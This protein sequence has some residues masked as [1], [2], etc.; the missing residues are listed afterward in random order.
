MSPL[1]LDAW[2][3]MAWLK[4]QRPASERVRLLLDA[5]DRRDQKLLMN[6]VNLGEVFY[7]SSK[8]KSVA[9]GERVLQGLRSRISIAS[10]SDELVMQAARL[11]AAHAISYADAFAAATAMAHKTPLV[12]GDMELRTMAEREKRL[13]IEW[14][15]G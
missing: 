7:L 9:Y 2:A 5:A 15:G 6:I 13:K 14:I 12:T 11:K 10:A 1:V 3:I 4:G 8:A